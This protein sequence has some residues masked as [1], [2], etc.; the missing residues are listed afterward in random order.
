MLRCDIMSYFKRD[1]LGKMP[2]V[3]NDLL[4]HGKSLVVC[5]KYAQNLLCSFVA[6]YRTFWVLQRRHLMN[7][8]LELGFSRHR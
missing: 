6:Y 2:W 5:S 4:S 8:Y 1:S 3:M 7:A